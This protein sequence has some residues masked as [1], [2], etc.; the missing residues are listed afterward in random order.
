V[1]E[2][3]Q[4]SLPTVKAVINDVLDLVLLFSRYQVRRWPRVVGSMRRGFTIRGQQGGVEHVMDGPAHGEIELI[5]N[6]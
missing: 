6:W 1:Y 5:G 2:I 4:G 3:L